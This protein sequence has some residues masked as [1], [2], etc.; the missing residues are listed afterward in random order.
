[1]INGSEESTPNTK[2][3]VYLMFLQMDK[4]SVFSGKSRKL[5]N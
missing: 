1:M 4:K 2:S 3:C 5:R